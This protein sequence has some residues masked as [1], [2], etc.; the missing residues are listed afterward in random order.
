MMR[1]WASHRALRLP[2]FGFRPG[3][4]NYADSFRQAVA[5]SILSIAFLASL[6][7]LGFEGSPFSQLL[8]NSAPAP[9]QPPG[10][11]MGNPPAPN[12]GADD[13]TGDRPDRTGVEARVRSDAVDVDIEE[14]PRGGEDTGPRVRRI[15]ISSDPGTDRTYSAEDEILVTVTFSRAVEVAGG[16]GLFLRVGA[17]VKQA[18][19]RSGSGSPLLVFAYQVAEGDQDSDGVSIEAGSLLFDEGEIGDPSGNAVLPDHEGLEADPRHRVDGVRPVLLEEEAELDGDQLVLS[20]AEALDG[21]TTPE[22]GDFRVTLAGES[23]EV[24]EVAVEGSEV[25]LTLATPAEA[26]QAAAVSY[27]VEAESAGQAVRDRAGNSAEGFTDHAVVNLTG[28]ALPARAVRQ[29]QAI[30]EAKQR[31]TPAQRKV[32]SQLLE[33]WQEAQGRPG[34]DRKVT[35]DIRAEVTPEVLE[36]IRELGGH[37]RQQRRAL[38][39]HPGGAAAVRGGGAGRPRGRPV[40][41]HR[42]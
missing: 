8:L 6:L 39:G 41:S 42:R 13:S 34:A 17:E 7:V 38:P 5:T 22:A 9:A 10:A 35:V 23:R 29:I 3:S 14:Q 25:R 26:G 36:R 33:E 15:E 4:R 37:G 31:R 12:L 2:V 16:P 11:E 27:E 24:L 30:L 19:Y 1:F 21:D 28:G 18:L 32:D 20:F 40:H